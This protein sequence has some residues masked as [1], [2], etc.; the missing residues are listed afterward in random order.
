RALPLRRRTEAGPRAERAEDARPATAADICTA[1]MVDVGKLDR[2]VVLRAHVPVVEVAER[3][4][5]PRHRIEAAPVAQLAEHTGPATAAHIRAAVVVQVREMDRG[6]EFG[7]GVPV[8]G[9][10]EGGLP[11]GRVPK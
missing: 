10:T 4:R 5:P 8:V 1:V 2:G 6:V 3:R 9:I 7:T 11:Q